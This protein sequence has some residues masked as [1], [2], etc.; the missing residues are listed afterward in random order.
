MLNSLNQQAWTNRKLDDQLSQKLGES[1]EACIAI[2]ELIE[3]QLQDIIGESQDFK[4]IV[5]QE[6]EVSSVTYL[7]IIYLVG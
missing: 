7:A 1:R 3:L 4:S 5:E 6:K 2:I